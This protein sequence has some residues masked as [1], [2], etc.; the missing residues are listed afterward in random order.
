MAAFAPAAAIVGKEM[1]LSFPVSRRK[2]SSASAAAISLS[3]PPGALSENQCRKRTTAAVAQL[4]LTRPFELGFVLL[5]FH[6]GNG[7][8]A[9]LGHAASILKDLNELR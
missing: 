8:G 4:R 5:S 6:K 3:R 2:V 7:I 9:Y 1:S